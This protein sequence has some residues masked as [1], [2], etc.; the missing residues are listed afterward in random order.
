VEKDGTSDGLLPGH[1]CIS[2]GFSIPNQP[3]RSIDGTIHTKTSI[4][5]ACHAAQIKAEEDSKII[6]LVIATLKNK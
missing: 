6:R 1:A 4:F 5:H 3:Y 2:C